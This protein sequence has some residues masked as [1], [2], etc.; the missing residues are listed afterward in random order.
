MKLAA[1]EYYRCL[2]TLEHSLKAHAIMACMSSEEG[3]SLCA[4]RSLVSLSRRHAGTWL[5]LTDYMIRLCAAG[6]VRA[7]SRNACKGAFFHPIHCG[8]VTE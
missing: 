3:C 5:M 6:L 8:L 2:F 4:S 7:L 1:V